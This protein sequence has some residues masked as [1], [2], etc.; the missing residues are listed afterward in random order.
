MSL[1]DGHSLEFKHFPKLAKTQLDVRPGLLATLTFAGDRIK[2]VTSL[3]STYGKIS[4]A[5]LSE[6]QLLFGILDRK[7]AV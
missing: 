7:A 5:P 3:G 2:N 4:C 6:M 1:R